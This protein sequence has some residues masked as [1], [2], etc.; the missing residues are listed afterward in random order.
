MLPTLAL[1]AQAQDLA[2]VAGEN[3][4]IRAR[5]SEELD[6][7]SKASLAGSRGSI[8]H[9]LSPILGGLGALTV[10]LPVITEGIPGL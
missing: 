10:H 7:F 3:A 2:P 8:S 6:G 4:K 5:K 1:R 9:D